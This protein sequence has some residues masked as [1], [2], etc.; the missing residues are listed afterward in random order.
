[1][2]ARYELKRTADRQY[3]W[4]LI[5]PNNEVILTSERYTTKAGAENGIGRALLGVRR[6]PKETNCP[7]GRPC[8]TSDEYWPPETIKAAWG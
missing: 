6:M 8:K 1:M 4:N 2:R 7:A 3:L 5:A